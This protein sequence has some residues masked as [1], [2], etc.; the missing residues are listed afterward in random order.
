[1][2]TKKA[3]PM[4]SMSCRH[5]PQYKDPDEWKQVVFLYVLLGILILASTVYAL[6]LWKVWG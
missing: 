3:Q 4:R 6:T 5:G 1:M 2:K